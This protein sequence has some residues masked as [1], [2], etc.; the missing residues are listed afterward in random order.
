MKERKKIYTLIGLVV[1]L[2]LVYLWN[3]NGSTVS[4]GVLASDAKFRPI[5]VRDPQLRLDLLQKVHTLEY[6]G[7]HRNIFSATPPP[8]VPKPG[9]PGSPEAD[10][11]HDQGPKLPPPPPPV[12]I[13]AT[14]FGFAA[15]PHTGSRL[16]FFQSGDDVFVLSEGGVLLDRYRLLKI[17]NDSAEFQEISTQR[18]ASLPITQPANPPENGRPDMQTPQGPPQGD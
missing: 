13:T 5:D 9:E 15:D 8:V 14:Y 4:T 12:N 3:H 16:A 1:L 11:F 2:A 6:N 17:G 7:T 18:H 10:S